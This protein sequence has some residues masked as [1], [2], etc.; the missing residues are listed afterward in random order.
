MSTCLQHAAQQGHRT[1]S[2]TTGHAILLASTSPR[3]REIMRLAGLE[4]DAINPGVDDGQLSPQDATPGAW[5]A[6]MAYLKAS[7]GLDKWRA[8]GQGRRTVIGADT[9]CVHAGVII[10][11]PIDAHDAGSMLAAF[12]DTVHQV[13]T[14]VAVIDSSTGR[15]DIFVDQATVW[16]DGV[17]TERIE[18]YVA[19]GLWKGKAGAYNLADRLEAGWPIRYEG[20]AETIMGLPIGL[21]RARLDQM[22]VEP[23]A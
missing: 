11:Q 8:T 12:D 23:A 3:R 20:S 2:M 22:P 19:G 6:A 18:T 9:I 17:G 4:H 13:L 21:L 14:G 7:A 5:V 15:R 16:W 1:F 10:G